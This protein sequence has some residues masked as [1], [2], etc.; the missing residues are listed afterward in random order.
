MI[1]WETLTPISYVSLSKISLFPTLLDIL[2]PG[3]PAI[4]SSRQKTNWNTC[5]RF[6]VT[7]L[8][9]ERLGFIGM[10]SFSAPI[11]CIFIACLAKLPYGEWECG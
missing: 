11:Q 2:V 10:Y 9:V 4:M 6:L 7:D 3:G 1:D 8:L 5:V